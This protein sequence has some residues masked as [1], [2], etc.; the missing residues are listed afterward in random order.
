VL[1][2]CRKFWFSIIIEIPRQLQPN[3]ELF[4]RATLGCTYAELKASTLKS[5]ER[6]T[7]KLALWDRHA[8]VEHKKSKAVL[9]G[10]QPGDW[11]PSLEIITGWLLIAFLEDCA[12]ETLQELL[13]T[14]FFSVDAKKFSEYIWF[15]GVSLSG[16]AR[17]STV[18]VMTVIMDLLRRTPRTYI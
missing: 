2:A 17:S 7:C 8:L 12:S 15:D 18:T 1:L 3:G 11:F 13:R 5:V 10:E 14:K 16:K 9:E 6:G 4:L